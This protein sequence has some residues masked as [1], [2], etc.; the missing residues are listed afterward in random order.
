MLLKIYV[1]ASWKGDLDE[2]INTARDLINNDLL[3]EAVFPE[4]PSERQVTDEY[5]KLI[6]DCD[7]LLVILGK[8]YSSHV[9]NEINHAFKNDIPVLC[10]VKKCDKENKLVDLISKIR[11]SVVSEDFDVTNLNKEIKKA[12]MKILTN[13]FKDHAEI[14]KQILALISSGRIQVIKPSPSRKDYIDVPKINPYEM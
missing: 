5:L 10:F 6:N 11:I 14:Q 3:M 9:E 4:G 7:I 1:S 2:E 13:K 12:I 8:F